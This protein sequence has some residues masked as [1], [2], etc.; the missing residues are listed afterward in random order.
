MKPI[1]AIV[2]PAQIDVDLI[3]EQILVKASEESQ[4]DAS[5]ARHEH[6]GAAAR[7]TAQQRRLEIGRLLTKARPAWPERGKPPAAVRGSWS[8][9]LARVK[10][11]QA[12]AWN[13]MELHKRADETG[14]PPGSRRELGLDS[15]PL[16]AD[17]AASAPTKEQMAAQMADMAAA[18]RAWLRKALRPAR[19]PGEGDRDSWCTP[20]EITAALP[21]VDLD[22]CSNPRSTVRAKVSCQLERD[23]DGLTVAWRGSLWLNVPFGDPEPWAIKFD[24]ERGDPRFPT[25]TAAGW[26]CNTDSTTEWWS[27]MIK[28]LPLRL[29]LNDRTAFVPPP[30]VKPSTND[31]AQTLLM[32]DAFWRGCDQPALLKLGTLWRRSGIALT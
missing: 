19:E 7:A 26:L 6:L 2:E 1:P 12:T 27:L 21:A 17:R 18:D 11:T 23:E 32:D 4:A 5:G 9:F 3:A 30:G 31:R 25:I 14:P 22:P 8:D 28:H 20:P 13:Y 15:R 16:A 24:A 10:M 29:D